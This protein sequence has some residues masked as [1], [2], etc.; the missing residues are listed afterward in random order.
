MVYTYR[1]RVSQRR[2]CLAAGQNRS[3]QRHP[4]PLSDI[5]QQQ[6]CIRF[7]SS[8]VHVRSGRRLVYTLLRHLKGG[9]VNHKRVRWF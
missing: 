7:G 2:A 1:F 9:T 6:L 3:P 5:E 4:M 8:Q